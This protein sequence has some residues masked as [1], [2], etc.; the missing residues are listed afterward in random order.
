[1]GEIAESV[2][3]GGRDCVDMCIHGCVCWRESRI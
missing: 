1:M 2:K 3:G